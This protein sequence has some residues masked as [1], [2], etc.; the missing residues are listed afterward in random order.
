VAHINFLVDFQGDTL[1][2]ALATF[3]QIG[4]SVGCIIE[5][6][7]FERPHLEEARQWLAAEA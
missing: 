1:D 5:A 7:A 3:L 2:C 4:L 6:K